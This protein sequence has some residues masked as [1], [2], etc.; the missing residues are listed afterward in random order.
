MQRRWASTSQRKRLPEFLGEFKFQTKKERGPAPLH[1]KPLSE[2][3]FKN[4]AF[5]TEYFSVIPES[6]FCVPFKIALESKK[7]C[8]QN[9]HSGI[10]NH[11]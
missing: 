11:G 3:R 7:I 2:P 5:E 10:L 4:L 9:L 1:P 6:S 8:H